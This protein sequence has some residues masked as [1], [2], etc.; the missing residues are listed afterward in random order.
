MYCLSNIRI[1]S[2]TKAPLFV[3]EH[4]EVVGGLTRQTAA[5]GAQICMAEALAN[6]RGCRCCY[7]D[8]SPLPPNAP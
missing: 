6:S 2:S 3:Q 1:Y 5:A 4:K 8:C 7:Y